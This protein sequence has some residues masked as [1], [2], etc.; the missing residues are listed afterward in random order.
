MKFKKVFRGYDA[1]QVDEYIRQSQEAE[2]QLRQA[3]KERIDELAEENASLSS[4]LAQYKTD[5]QA[6]SKSLIDSQKLA[7]ELKH[8]AEKYSE[9]V[10]ARA[11][12]FYAT[13]SAYA[14][15]LIAALS[16]DEVKAFNRLQAKIENIINAYEGKNVAEDSLGVVET[17]KNQTDVAA[18]RAEATPSE[19]TMQQEY[20]NPISKVQQA[21]DVAI[22]LR[23]LV[24]TDESLEQLCAELGLTVSK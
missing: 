5:E 10:L 23:E 18:A 21:S 17:A 1:K 7:Q 8:D 11:K 22:D 2:A 24:T 12:I 9:L 13:W 20:Q 4:Q 19:T 14:Q 3:Q 6:I 16:D 15:T